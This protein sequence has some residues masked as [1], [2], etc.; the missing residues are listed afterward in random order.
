[1]AAT[2]SSFSPC[3]AELAVLQLRRRSSCRYKESYYFKILHFVWGAQRKRVNCK[4]KCVLLFV[5]QVTVPDSPDLVNEFSIISTTRSFTLT[6]RQDQYSCRSWDAL[7]RSFALM[8]QE[9]VNLLQFCFFF[10]TFFSHILPSF[11]S[12][13]A[14]RERDS[15]CVTLKSRL[16]KRPQESRFFNDALITCSCTREWSLGKRV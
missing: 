16:R 1:M 12:L 3:L 9:R 13:S 6:A 10:P 14:T 11:F 15:Y 2:P 8:M 4:F 5:C 7:K